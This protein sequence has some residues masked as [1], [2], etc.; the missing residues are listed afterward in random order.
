MK[1][2]ARFFSFCGRQFKK[3]GKKVFV[4]WDI[5][6][7]VVLV[8]LGVSMATRLGEA[9]YAALVRRGKSCEF[10]MW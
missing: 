9:T 5:L 10:G 4:L 6:G 8:D 3:V 7:S 1:E 2:R